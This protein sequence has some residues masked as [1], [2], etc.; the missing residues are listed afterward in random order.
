MKGRTVRTYLFFF[1]LF[2]SLSCSKK[3]A[4]EAAEAIDIALT[5]LGK[6]ECDDAIKVLEDLDDMEDNAIYLQVLASA[7]A[8][9]AAYNEVAV[10]DSLSNLVTTTPASVFKSIATMTY[11]METSA[12]S[13]D[14]VNLRRAIN[15]LLGSTSGAPSHVSRV[16]KFGPRKA[17]DMSVQSL[18][19][20]ITNFGKFL[21]YYGNVD[22][23]GNKGQGSNTNVCFLDYTDSDAQ[24]V[25]A[26]GAGGV[27]NNNTSGHP[28]LDLTTATGR[29]RVCEGLMLLTNVFDILDNLDLSSSD[30]LAALEEVSTQ[31]DTYRAGAVAVGLGYLFDITSQSECETSMNTP[32]NLADMEYLFA[33]VFETG[34]Q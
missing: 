22:T 3:P 18:L 14:Y 29:R 27:C 5:H 8:C 6:E 19:L 12:D 7:Y 21:N 15:I 16:A 4:E 25:I 32:A 10:V 9:K 28:D 31:V 34:L 26:G 30:Q 2:I 1:I 11:S 17:G 20:N 33:L 13:D 24:S 23:L